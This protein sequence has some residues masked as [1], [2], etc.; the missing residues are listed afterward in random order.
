MFSPHRYNNKIRRQEELVLTQGLCLPAPPQAAAEAVPQS[1]QLLR[2]FPA[3]ERVEHTYSL[4]SNTAGTAKHRKQTATVT[5]PAEHE[6]EECDGAGSTPPVGQ[7]QRVVVAGSI[8]VPKTTLYRH[9]AREQQGLVPV[10]K[11]KRANNFCGCCNKT[12]TKETGHSCQR[13]HLFCPEN[14]DGLTLQQWYDRL[15][16]TVLSKYKK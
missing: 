1:H 6:K 8:N 2:Q 7:G 13:G 9:R 12:R 4:P 3:Y 16:A 5:A 10:N 14:T 11:R 15:Y